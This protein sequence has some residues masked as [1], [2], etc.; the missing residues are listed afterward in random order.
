MNAHFL[1]VVKR[2]IAEQG[3]GILADPQRLKSIIKDYAKDEPKEERQAFGRC[4]EQGAYRALE[5]APDA[6]ERASRKAAIARQVCAGAGLDMRRCSEALDMLEAAL[7]DGQTHTSAHTAA[8]RRSAL[9]RNK[10][11]LYAIAAA[12]LIAAAIGSAVVS[13]HNPAAGT[14][15]YQTMMSMKE[16]V[17]AAGGNVDGTLR[18]SIQWNDGGYNP[19]DFDA[20]CIEPDGNRIYFPPK[21]ATCRAAILI[22]TL[23]NPSGERP[24]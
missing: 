15:E 23:L 21:T 9:P 16:R 5:T 3:E 11:L 17:K 13:R 12:V 10:A 4:I 20:H 24:P 2:I 14:E 7:F 8:P 19:N 18:F 1:A 6:A 22:L